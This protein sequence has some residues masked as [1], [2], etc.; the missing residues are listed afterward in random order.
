MFE[1]CDGSERGVCRTDCRKER[2]AHGCETGECEARA[3]S[4]PL[5]LGIL[6]QLKASAPTVSSTGPLYA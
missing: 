6:S 3:D 4:S 1:P 5:L 2:A